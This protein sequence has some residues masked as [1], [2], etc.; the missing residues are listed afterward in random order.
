MKIGR[1]IKRTKTKPNETKPRI[2]E[3]KVS[4]HLR[5]L[6]SHWLWCVSTSWSGKYSAK[7]IKRNNRAEQEEEEE[8]EEEEEEEEEEVYLVLLHSTLRV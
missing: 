3:G 4:L 7:R 2:L 1:E 6:S 8:V 5:W